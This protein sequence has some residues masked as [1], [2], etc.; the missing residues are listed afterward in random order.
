M[1]LLK[2]VL[3]TV[4]ALA[5]LTGTSVVAGA[6][7]PEQKGHEHLNCKPGSVDSAGG[8]CTLTFSDKDKNDIAKA[9]QQICFSVSPANAGT[10]VGDGTIPG[11]GNCSTTD[12]KGNAT[13]TFTADPSGCSGTKD[14]DATVDGQETSPETTGEASTTVQIKCPKPAPK[15]KPAP[16]STNSAAHLALGTSSTTGG[17]TG[18]TML[19]LGILAAVLMLSVAITGRLRLRRLSR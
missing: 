14:D 4:A 12:S 10:V 17:S 5:A 9:G 19:G 2:T 18:G 15:S 8:Q 3:A 13:A 1:R 11:S 16:N 7:Y 6:T